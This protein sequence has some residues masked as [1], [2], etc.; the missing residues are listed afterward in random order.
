MNTASEIVTPHIRLR[1]QLA[2]TLVAVVLLNISIIFVVV[3]GLNRLRAP[4][5]QLDVFSTPVLIAILLLGGLLL[6]ITQARYGYRQALDHIDAQPIDDDER[7]E[8][9]TQVTRLALAANI[10]KPEVAVIDEPTPNSFSVGNGTTA[11]IVVTTGLLDVLNDDELHAVLA[12]EIAHIANRDTTV[13]TILAS[14]TAI[15]QSLFRRERAL[16]D[17]LR[18]A[19]AIAPVSLILLV[20]AIPL[21]V[22]LVVYLIVSLVARVILAINAICTGLHAQTREYTADRA[23][24][25]LTGR[26]AALAS[27]LQTLSDD[28]RP[29]TDFRISV[30]ASLGI[31][32]RMIHQRETSSRTSGSRLERW[33]GSDDLVANSWVHPESLLSRSLGRIARALEWRPTTHP[34]TVERIQRLKEMEAR[35]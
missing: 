22:V 9:V 13:A 6:T 18:V 8:L 30:D 23:A 28:D 2:I 34:P 11:S 21:I 15:S 10:P 1:T 3:S 26:P 16:A 27:A 32:P 24:A 7:H 20:Y 35:Q 12:H 29:D 19:I 4:T 5:W 33:F 31:V 17:W 25:E 14:F